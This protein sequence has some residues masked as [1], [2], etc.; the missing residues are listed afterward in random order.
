[1]R[2][3]PLLLTAF[4]PLLAHAGD[5]FVCESKRTGSS[6]L[7][8][9]NPIFDDQSVVQQTEEN[10]QRLRLDAS[11]SKSSFL[12]VLQDDQKQQRLAFSGATA[13]VLGAG[14]KL[15]LSE[16]ELGCQKV[17]EKIEPAFPAGPRKDLPRFFVCLLDEAE[18]EEGAVKES[19]RRF[20]EVNP[21]YT[22]RKP[23]KV[24]NE[25]ALYAFSVRFD[26]FDPVSGLKIEITDKAT[27][28][29]ARFS[30]PARALGNSFLFGFTQGDKE[31]NAKFLRL[32]C[33]YANDP[34]LF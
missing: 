34:K 13:A 12:F 5:A 25:D 19:K 11:L 3:F 33:T 9:A 23:L 26:Q 24:Q 4:I 18:F 16:S 28:Q 31:K 27:R 10:S 30:G 7:V 1:M 22:F 15:S 29:T 17:E 20:L 8:L 32:G 21:A 6:A 14:A 2:F